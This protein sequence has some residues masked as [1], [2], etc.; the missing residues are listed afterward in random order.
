[1]I[2]MV[3]LSFLLGY[4]LFIAIAFLLARLLFPDLKKVAEKHQ[5][6]RALLLHRAKRRHKEPVRRTVVTATRPAFR[7]D[8]PNPKL[9]S[10]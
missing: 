10:Q 3:I 5:N 9:V 2:G 1:M 6:E 8:V 4:P 7:L